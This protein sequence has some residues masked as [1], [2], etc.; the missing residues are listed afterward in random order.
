LPCQSST[1]VTAISAASVFGIPDK[2]CNAHTPAV[3]LIQRTKRFVVMVVD[4]GEVAQLSRG[5]VV[6]RPQESQLTRSRAQ[7]VKPVGQKRRVVAPDLPDQHRRPI[8]QHDL[9]G[10]GGVL[11]NAV[12]PSVRGER[13]SRTITSRSDGTIITYCPI[14]PLAKNASR[15]QPCSVR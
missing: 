11:R 13:P 14:V 10:S 7:P 6:L 8:P 2:A 9:P 1:I 15:G 3:R 12:P 4:I 5:Q